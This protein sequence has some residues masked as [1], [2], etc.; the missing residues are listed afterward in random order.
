MSGDASQPVQTARQRCNPQKVAFPNSFA[1]LWDLGTA[2][3][4]NRHSQRRCD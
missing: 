4:L 2:A 1:P 3:K